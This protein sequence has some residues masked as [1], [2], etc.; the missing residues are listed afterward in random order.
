LHINLLAYSLHMFTIISL[1][2]ED[3]I[4]Y[5]TPRSRHMEIYSKTILSLLRGLSAKVTYLVTTCMM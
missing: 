1:I 5:G 4:P 3:D 2:I